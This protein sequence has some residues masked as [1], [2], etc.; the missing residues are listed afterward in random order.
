[1]LYT[2][3]MI[4]ETIVTFI[5]KSFFLIKIASINSIFYIKTELNSGN[6]KSFK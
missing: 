6:T 4:V 1:M 3:N 2:D 5:Y